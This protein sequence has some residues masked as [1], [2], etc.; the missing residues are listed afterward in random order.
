MNLGIIFLDNRASQPF[1]ILSAP[2]DLKIFAT[3][4]FI[5]VEQEPNGIKRS[6]DNGE[7]I[8]GIS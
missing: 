2:V 3:D 6:F 7:A 8:R 4:C 1:Q 5:Y